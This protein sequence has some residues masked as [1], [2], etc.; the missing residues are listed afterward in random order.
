MSTL[1]CVRVCRSVSKVCVCVCVCVRAWPLL[2]PVGF[3]SILMEMDTPCAPGERGSG[4]GRYAEDEEDR[5]GSRRERRRH[6]CE[7]H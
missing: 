6:L 4:R 7:S 5:G 2:L 1:V 3:N